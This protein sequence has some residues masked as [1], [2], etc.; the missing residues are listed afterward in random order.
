MKYRHVVVGHTGGPEVLHVVEDDLPV[1]GPGQARVKI[2]AADVSFTDVNLRRGRYPGAPQPPFT[3]GYAMVGVVDQ[4]GPQQSARHAGA[5]ALKLTVGQAVAALTVYGSYSQYLCLPVSELVPMPDRLDPAEAVCLVLNY[6]GAYQMLHRIAHVTRGERILVHGAA[7]GI[8]TAFLELGH[9][10]GLEMYGT[11]SRP[12]HDL[13]ARLG[14][15]PIDYTSEDFVARIAALTSGQGMDAAFD[16]MGA[17]HLRQSTR[18]V[19]RGGTVVGYGFYAAANRGGNIVLDVLSQYMQV[20]VGALSPSRK[21]VAFYD[22]RPLAKKH[23]EWFRE[24][25]TAL[26]NLLGA[27]RLRPVIAARLPLDEVVRAHQLV[28]HAEVQGKLVLIPNP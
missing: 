23:P 1:P 3:P 24:D 21:H 22:I 4:L 9:L 25:L 7:G 12:K 2:L 18:A 13:V 16:P 26:L 6:V 11:A 28:E 20:A 19:R 15:T 17:A 5:E 8:G 14:A 10:A 27:G